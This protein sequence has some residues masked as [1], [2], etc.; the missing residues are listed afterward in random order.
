MITCLYV[1]WFSRL[2]F[3]FKHRNYVTMSLASVK[4]RLVLPFWYWLAWVVPEKRP[5]NGV[6]AVVVMVAA[7][8][9]LVAGF[10]VVVRAPAAA[11]GRQARAEEE[12][13]ERLLQNPRSR[14]R[15]DR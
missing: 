14:Q 9:I 3:I 1:N 8:I 6:A 5:L 7:V 13:A 11:A 2:V 4:S 10:V 15:R 12:Q